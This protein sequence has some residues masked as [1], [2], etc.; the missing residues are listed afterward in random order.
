MKYCNN[1]Y[2][3]SRIES[4][5]VTIG[6]IPLGGKN[7]IR[8][9]S[10]I[11]TNTLDTEKSVEQIKKIADA[12]ADYV[13]LTAPGTKDAQN[14]KVIKEK[15][16][17]SGYDLPIIAD[18]H[19]NPQ[20]A[21]IA[22]EFVEKVRINPGN[23]ADKRAS[24]KTVEF[25]DEEY[26][27]ELLRIKEKL[28]PLLEICKRRNVAIRIGTNH[29]SLSDRI[30]TRYGDT[31][32]GMVESVMEFLRICESEDFKEIVISLKSSNTRVLVQAYRLMSS[33][34]HNENMN[35]P[36]HLGV[37]EAGEGEDGRIKSAVGIGTLLADGIGDT[38]RV[39]LTE[40]PE[41]EVPVAQK[42]VDYF[43][44]REDHKEIKDLGLTP[45]DPYEYE[46]RESFEL[47]NIGGKHVP[48]VILE[49]NDFFKDN[50]HLAGYDRN[51]KGGYLKNDISA[52][53]ILLENM[54]NWEIP[55]G[56][57]IIVP[58]KRYKNI[59]NANPLFTVKEFLRVNDNEQEKVFIEV[60]YKKFNENVLNKIKYAKNAIFIFKAK[61]KNI[62]AEYRAF[63]MLL[64]EN[65][66]KN[67]VILKNKYSETEIED[68]QIK[69]SAD[70]GA[71]FI[72]GFGDGICISNKQK[73]ANFELDSILNTSFGILQASRVRVSKT[74][75]ISCPGC[76]RT[77]F[78]LQETTAKIRER[79]AHLKG[80][81]IGIMGCI[82]NG[83]GEMADADYGYVGSGINKIILYK[84]RTVVKRNVDQDK[85]VDELINL[86]KANGD[87]V[88][89]E[90]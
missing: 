60:S 2:K 15:L 66:I 23:Y 47:G 7:P 10:M 41:K 39:S 11:N 5:E 4:R 30:M 43:A 16:L 79:T 42:L 17:E 21:I 58:Y 24:F 40:D 33:Q 75:Y 38:V 78:E 90:K 31:P 6:K 22:A 57:E 27:A 32:E 8:I 19:F 49:E 83:P 1:L 9:Q 68:F 46:K 74:E 81:K 34:M 65:G 89:S 28:L 88:D 53:Y 59:K 71:L 84:G 50:L 52:E 56:L 45:P 73:K 51:N 48:V 13:R 82:V 62:F 64:L 67:P 61:T 72:E 25:S 77:L 76:G 26:D 44:E 55:D 63:F 70:I 37:T 35:Y 85:A 87:W 29:G 54:P 14:L 36:L 12:G 69:S 3:Y 86:I 18:I 20:A 80:L